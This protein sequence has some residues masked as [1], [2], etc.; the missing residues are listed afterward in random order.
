M[1]QRRRRQSPAPGFAITG[2]QL[3][4]IRW[5]VLFDTSSDRLSRTEM[6]LRAL[7]VTTVLI[8]T[9]MTM[10]SVLV[11]DNKKAFESF[12]YFIICLF[13]LAN[14][15]LAVRTKRFSRAMLL[16]LER[17]LP[18]Y[19]RPMPRWLRRR[20]ADDR[21]SCDGFTRRVIISYLTLVVFEVPA[22]AAMPLAAAVL[23]D[24]RLGSQS[25]QMVS[26][27][28]PFDTDQVCSDWRR[29]PPPV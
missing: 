5:S 26:S 10:T 27:Y 28:F 19:D 15:L 17:E 14:I 25:T 24:A 12:T 11:A 1:E 3:F 22:T 16:M 29:R 21:A 7:Q 8:T 20:L 18:A 6:M 23:T 13:M 4:C 9:V 2:F